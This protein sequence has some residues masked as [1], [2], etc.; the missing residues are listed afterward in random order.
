MSPTLITLIGINDAART[1]DIVRM[2]TK[3]QFLYVRSA[4]A[5]SHVN[6]H[7]KAALESPSQCQ[8]SCT[9]STRSNRELEILLSV[10][11]RSQKQMKVNYASLCSRGGRKSA[12]TWFVAT[13]M[14]L[15][16]RVHSA[17]CQSLWKLRRGGPEVMTIGKPPWASA[18]IAKALTP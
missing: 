9:Y 2:Q 13:A 17:C 8:L 11:R 16:H 6:P 4:Y 10:W 15:Q 1:N 12:F 5:C 3:Y 18:R 14:S 7:R